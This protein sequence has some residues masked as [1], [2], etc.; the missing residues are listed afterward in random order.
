M[1]T[2]DLYVGLISGTS[3]DGVDCA[4]VQFEQD[5]PTLLCSHFKPSPDELRQRVLQICSGEKLDLSTIGQ[6]DTQVG[7][8]FAEG[9]NELLEESGTKPKH[10]TA[11]GS[12]GQTFWHQP[13]GLYPFSMQLGDP[14]S[15]AFHTG[16]TTVA[17]FRRM[18]I[19]AGGQGAPLAPL[20]HRN[21]FQS[22]EHSRA[23]VNIG[24]M[25]NLTCL[26]ANGRCSAFDSG[27]GNVL[28][29]YW[30]GK[31]QNLRFDE[32]GQW[33]AS[34]TVNMGLLARL[35][36]ESYF[37]LSSPK[38]T[39]RELFNSEW[40]ESRLKLIPE[41]AAAD[42]QATLLALTAKTIA[43]DLKKAMVAEALYVCG[44]GA[45]NAALMGALAAELPDTE[46]T[47]SEA[48]GMDPDWVEAIAFAW[49]ARERIEGRAID[50]KPFTG[51]VE[52]IMLGGVYTAR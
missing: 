12:H 4:L 34:G 19:V 6:I 24:G 1:P 38:S 23:V 22:S 8:Y 14:N 10:V 21:V 2:S 39:G 41:I 28:M 36:D 45:H 20:L 26:P 3:V 49:M 11:I 17:D 32:D 47:S 29:D 40:L 5:Q 16:I 25:S 15:I 44:G 37:A 46:V 43:T 48:L 7:R 35:L 27:P 18:D 51:A 9:V 33:A 13:A 31:H 52:P 42:V 50:T 30:I